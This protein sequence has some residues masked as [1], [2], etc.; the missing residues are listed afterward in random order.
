MT[1]NI[2]R[3]S[4]T[5]IDFD[6]NLKAWN[7]EIKA[8]VIQTLLNIPASDFTSERTF[9]ALKTLAQE[10]SWKIPQLAKPVRVALT[11]TLNSPDLG[12]CME[13]LGSERV[14]SRLTR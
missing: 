6:E 13:A 5:D 8:A 9:G 10:K 4:T 3:F 2:R 14:I 11:G 12:I 1:I 7:P